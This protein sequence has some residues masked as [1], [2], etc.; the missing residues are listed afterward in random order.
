MEFE[1]DAPKSSSNKSKHG[2]DFAEA[3]ALWADPWFL[4]ASARTTDEPRFLAVGR[5][6]DRHWTAVFALRGSTIRLISVRRSRPEEVERYE[7]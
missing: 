4:E 7:G 2:I 3:Q 1:F 5:I 6:A